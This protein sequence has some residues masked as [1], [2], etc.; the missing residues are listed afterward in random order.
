MVAMLAF[1]LYS[2]VA[3]GSSMDSCQVQAK[4]IL[5]LYSEPGLA[6]VV[7]ILREGEPVRPATYRSLEFC[8]SAGKGVS[9]CEAANCDHAQPVL[10]IT[11]A[12]K[13]VSL[14]NL[15]DAKAGWYCPHSHF[16][17]DLRKIG[18]VVWD[19]ACPLDR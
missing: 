18:A 8:G 7:V 5:T 10:R 16:G 15:R 9:L 1:S 17:G 6:G 4:S 3:G 14:S 13:L 19:P 11:S 2:K 12:G